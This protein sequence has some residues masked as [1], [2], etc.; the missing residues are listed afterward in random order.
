LRPVTFRL[1]APALPADCLH[2]LTD[3]GLPRQFNIHC[4][5]DITLKFSGTATPLAEI[6]KR[7]LDRGYQMGDMPSEWSRFWHLADQEYCQ[8]GGWICVEESTGRLLVIDLDQPEPIYLLNSSVGRFYT[9]LGH[10]LDWSEKTD[11]GPEVTAILRDA[12]L[13]QDCIPADELKRFG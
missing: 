7:D 10:F 5:N 4:C 13:N 2:L 1:P 12:L 6:W 9:T 11:G 8:G 3:Y